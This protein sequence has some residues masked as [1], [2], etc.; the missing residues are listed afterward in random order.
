MTIGSPLASAVSGPGIDDTNAIRFPSGDHATLVPMPGSGAFVPVISARN[1]APVPSGFAIA[2]PLLPSTRPRWAIHWPSGDH[3]GSPDDSFSP[4][5]RTLLP[6]ATVITEIWPYGRPGPSLL[7]TTYAT[8]VPSGE[9]WTVL[10]ARS[11]NRSLLC[12]RFCDDAA[13][14]M[15]SASATANIKH[16]RRMRGPFLCSRGPPRSPALAAGASM[17]RYSIVAH[18]LVRALRAL[19]AFGSS[20]VPMRLICVPMLA[21]AVLGATPD[22]SCVSQSVDRRSRACLALGRRRRCARAAHEAR[23]RGARLRGRHPPPRLLSAGRYR[24]RILFAERDAGA[25]RR[26]R[27]C[28]R[29][30]RGDRPHEIRTPDRRA[31]ERGTAD[32]ATTAGHPRWSMTII[33]LGGSTCAAPLA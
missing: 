31:P 10:T 12:T 24:E 27:P 18:L 2:S 13:Y 23:R 21:L 3:C 6:S 11:F 22:E 1:L 14:G 26:G 29:R 32:R 28:A 16:G 33:C 25:S 30:R 5:K 7:S 20:C 9:S 17:E 4:P 19:R 8:R 15:P